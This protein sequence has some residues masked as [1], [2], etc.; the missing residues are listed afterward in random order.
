MPLCFA[1]ASALALIIPALAT[2]A[3]AADSGEV[4]VYSYRQPYLIE[5]L[6]KEFTDETGIKVNVIFAEKGLIERI[7]AEGRNSPA[8]VLLTVDIGNLTQA[9]TAGI[10]Q[11]V[12]SEALDAA[13]PQA[14]R[15]KDDEW[16]GLTRRA[17]VIYASKDRVKQDMI[18]YEELADPK[19][20]GKICT[21]SGQHPYNVALIASM[22]AA[23]GEDWTEEWLKGV[24]ANLAR[25]SAGNDRLQVKG[26]YAGECDLALGNTYYMGAML[27]DEKE[28]EQKAWAESVNILFP[29]SAD[30]GTHINVSG[31]VLAK[32]APHKANAIKLVEF[33]AS[34]KGQEMYAEVN[35]E[36]P[37]KEGVPAS[38][39]VQ[40][41]GTFKADPISL[42]EIGGLRKTAS[43][44]VDKVGFDDGPSS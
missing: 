44:L 31:A 38:E 11:P 15:A 29:N 9:K 25:K 20:R 28:P 18:T 32:H 1:R 43:E 8:D 14:Y 22:I 30:R 7:Q 17:R 26:V 41:W 23:H 19:W 33:L 4:N 37:V 42:E 24:K 6:L 12:Q 13:V 3:Q 10:A 5:P 39:L 34:D 2:P 27:N 40:S 16:I 36:Y 35:Y 21:R